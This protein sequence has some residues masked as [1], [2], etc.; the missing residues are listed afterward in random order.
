VLRSSS[1]FDEADV[2]LVLRIVFFALL[3]P[4]TVTLLIPYVILSGMSAA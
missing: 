4:G 1:R 2:V 3:L